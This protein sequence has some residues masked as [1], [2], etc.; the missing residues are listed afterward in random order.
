M[1]G[2]L[3]EN[4]KIYGNLAKIVSTQIKKEV[5]CADQ[6]RADR[7]YMQ[8][9]SERHRVMEKMTVEKNNIKIA[10]KIASA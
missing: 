9:L 10:Q 7:D 5:I 6:H 8:K 4:K 2:L 1:D 3:S